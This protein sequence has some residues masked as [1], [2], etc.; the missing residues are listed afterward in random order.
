MGGFDGWWGFDG[1]S[2]GWAGDREVWMWLV[3]RVVLITGLYVIKWGQI[4]A[5]YNNE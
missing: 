5:L 2:L 4:L 1:L 3:M